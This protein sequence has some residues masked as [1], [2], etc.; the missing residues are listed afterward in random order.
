MRDAA[1]V[2][3]SGLWFRERAHREILWRLWKARWGSGCSSSSSLIALGYRGTPPAHDDVLR[4]GRLDRT[5][6][7][8]RSRGSARDH[9]FISPTRRRDGRGLRQVCRALYGRRGP[10]LFRISAGA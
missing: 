10:D 5:L 9:G 3:L 2:A 8:P 1:A 6:R 4:F 7:A